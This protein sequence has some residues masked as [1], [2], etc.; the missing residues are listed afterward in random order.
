MLQTDHTIAHYVVNVGYD[1][2]YAKDNVFTMDTIDDNET[3]TIYPP[4]PAAGGFQIKRCHLNCLEEGKYLN[5]IIL[6]FYLTY[7]L[8]EMISSSD[9]NRTH[10]FSSFFFKK[11]ASAQNKNNIPTKKIYE[12]VQKWTKNV[13]LFEKDFIIVPINERQI[14]ITIHHY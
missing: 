8:C 1:S 5:D 9:R 2:H 3:I 10:L 4:L 13:N 11:I 14:F 7:F 12:S 6:D